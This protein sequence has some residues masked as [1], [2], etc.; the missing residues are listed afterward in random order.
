MPL[1]IACCVLLTTLVHSENPYL[2]LLN[3]D[4]IWLTSGVAAGLFLLAGW[5][6]RLSSADWQDG[7]ACCSLLTWY[8]Y[9]KPLFSVGSPL[10]HVF[11]SYFALLGLWM[12]LGFINKSSRFDANSQAVVADLQVYLASFSSGLLALT[13][14]IG[15]A[16]PEHYLTYPLA[17]TFF[18]M[19]AAFQRCF[20]NINRVD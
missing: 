7:F 17:M 20:E 8:G 3:Q 1:F 6:N 15:I 11:P 9:W 19:R 14:L 10:L 5:I 18:I 4:E 12:L 13:V 2:P 16:L